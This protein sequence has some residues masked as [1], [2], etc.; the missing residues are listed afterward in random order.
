MELC[1]V[2]AM[3][4]R[5]WQLLAFLCIIYMFVCLQPSVSMWLSVLGLSQYEEVML[6]AGYDD[7]DF[8]CDITLDDLQDLGITKIGEH[9]YRQFHLTSLMA[10]LYL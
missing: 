10:I 9:C 4:L 3:W 6:E 2:A 8:I 7:I 5:L 1:L